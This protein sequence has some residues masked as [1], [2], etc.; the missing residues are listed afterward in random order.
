MNTNVMNQNEKEKLPA[1]LISGTEAFWHNNEKWIIHNGSTMRFSNAPGNLQRMIADRFLNDKHSIEIIK[2]TGI[3]GFTEGFDRWYH[4]VVGAI[5]EVPDFESGKLQPD[6]YNNQ[7]KNMDCELRGKLC[8]R[9]TGLKFYEVATLH[10]L[11]A[12]FN[13]TETARLLN[14][15]KAGLKSRIEKMKEKMG[16]TNMASMIAKAVEFGI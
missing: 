9:E 8:S 12:G 14:V 7:C 16:A 2:S 11:K 15:S 10:A 13:E 4:C 3:T 5:D 1:G 6:A